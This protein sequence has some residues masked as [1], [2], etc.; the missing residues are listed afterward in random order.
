MEGRMEQKR[1]RGRPRQELMD[2]MMED[3]YGKLKEKT[4]SRGVESLDIWTCREAD[5]LKKVDP[6]YLPVYTFNRS[7]H[8]LGGEQQGLEPNSTDLPEVPDTCREPP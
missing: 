7:L 4:T 8:Q 6:P 1:G 5:N 3:R 2:W